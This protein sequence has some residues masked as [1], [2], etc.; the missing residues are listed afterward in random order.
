[1]CVCVCGYNF[2]VALSWNH[3][4]LR[5]S[6]ATRILAIKTVIHQG[7]LLHLFVMSHHLFLNTRDFWSP[8]TT[9]CWTLTHSTLRNETRTT[10]TT[11]MTTLTINNFVDYTRIQ[12]STNCKS[13]KIHIV[14]QS[15]TVDFQFQ[16]SSPSFSFYLFLLFEHVSWHQCQNSIWPRKS[17]ALEDNILPISKYFKIQNNSSV[18]C[19]H[20]R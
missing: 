5:N 9:V 10:S 17:S 13:H 2:R 16:H 15:D 11:T 18:L 14:S 7:Q 3:N 20:T 12:V 1:M 8:T 6:T 19:Y 4:V